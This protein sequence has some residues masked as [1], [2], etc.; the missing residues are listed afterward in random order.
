MRCF[1]SV[2]SLFFSNFWWEA[3]TVKEPDDNE[4]MRM[5]WDINVRL[6]LRTSRIYYIR[7]TQ[8]TAV[9][10]WHA[11]PSDL[12]SPDHSKREQ[13]KW[14]PSEWSLI[15][16]KLNYNEW[17]FSSVAVKLAKPQHQQRAGHVMRRDIRQRRLRNGFFHHSRPSTRH[18]TQCVNAKKPDRMYKLNCPFICSPL[19]VASH[20][21]GNVARPWMPHF[22]C[23]LWRGK[24]EEEE[25]ERKKRLATCSHRV[26]QLPGV[27]LHFFV[28]FFRC[29]FF[30]L[31]SLEFRISSIHCL[32]FRERDAMTSL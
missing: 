25:G 3:A 29:T 2:F 5:T 4:M 30:S 21:V 8:H 7:D 26:F 1:C 23:T 14:S 32:V 31:H 27:L 15:Y 28:W 9:N 16:P 22:L 18:I 24:E 6:D 17:K 12:I 20:R 13:K 11:L 19:Q 10:A